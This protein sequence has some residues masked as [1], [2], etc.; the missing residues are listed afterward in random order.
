[1]SVIETIIELMLMSQLAS[2]LSRVE[3]RMGGDSRHDP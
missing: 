3:V 1:M 2:Y